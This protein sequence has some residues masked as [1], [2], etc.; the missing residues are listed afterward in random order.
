MNSRGHV[1]T[2]YY[3]FRIQQHQRLSHSQQRQQRHRLRDHRRSS[4]SLAENIDPSHAHLSSSVVS[5]IAFLVHQ[6]SMGQLRSRQQQQ[7]QQLRRGR[8]VGLFSSEY[9][10]LSRRNRVLLQRDRR[11]RKQPRLEPCCQRSRC[12]RP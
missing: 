1:S 12:S 10:W 4:R 11:C 8:T 5:L 9:R 6:A 2:E 3:S 7:Q